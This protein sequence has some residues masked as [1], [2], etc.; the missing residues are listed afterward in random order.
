MTNCDLVAHVQ[1]VKLEELKRREPFVSGKRK[2]VR[3]V[4]T[5]NENGFTG[6]D[7]KKEGNRRRNRAKESRRAACE[8]V[9]V[10]TRVA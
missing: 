2:T 10:T 1:E 5:A 3:Y 8:G 4:V 6:H 7:S 9:G